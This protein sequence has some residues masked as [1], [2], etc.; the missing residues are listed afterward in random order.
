MIRPAF[1]SGELLPIT[2]GPFPAS[3]GFERHLSRAMTRFR[4]FAL[5]ADDSYRGADGVTVNG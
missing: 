5:L 1:G 2:V 4:G 3:D